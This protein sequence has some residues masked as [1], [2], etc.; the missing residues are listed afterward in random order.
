M[1]GTLFFFW[2]FPPP[3]LDQTLNITYARAEK[4]GSTNVEKDCD[5]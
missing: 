3:D 2:T 4:N 5:V 1:S